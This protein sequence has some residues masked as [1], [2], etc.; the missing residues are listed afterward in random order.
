MAKIDTSQYTKAQWQIVKASRRKEKEE[1]RARKAQSNAPTEQDNKQAIP[2]VE[3]VIP[4]RES[5]VSSQPNTTKNYVVC[6]KHGSKYSS[7]YVNKLHSMCKRHLTVPFEFVCFTDD[8]RG[9]DGNIKT[10]AL[11]QNGLSGWWYKPMFFDKN[12]GVDGTLLYMDLDI[13]INANIDHLFTYQPDK[14]CII[15][16]FNRSIRHDWNRMNSS[17][18]RLKTGS[19]PYVYDN[20]MESHEVNIRRFHGD[21]DW[22]YEQVGPNKQEWVFWPDEWILSYKW[23]MRDRSQLV[24]V[25]G[26]PRNFKTTADPKV[27]PKTC[28]AVF[29]GEP[30]PHQ[31]EDAWVKENWK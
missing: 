11:K 17:V 30:H 4:P 8:L 28:I 18:F 26:Q 31:C 29:H 10:I 3:A 23:E 1:N 9:I 5:M 24:K 25:H 20:F 15:R 16:D 12:L 6:L 14:F 2:P 21:Q 27:L 19:L 13:V 7:E 22:I